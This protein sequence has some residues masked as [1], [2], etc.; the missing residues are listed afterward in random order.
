[1]TQIDE[2]PDVGVPSLASA[3]AELVVEHCS[4]HSPP[5]D[6]LVLVSDYPLDVLHATRSAILAMG[7]AQQF[8]FGDSRPALTGT[9]VTGRD[10]DVIQILPYCVDEDSEGQTQSQGYA[11]KLRDN[12]PYLLPKPARLRARWLILLGKPAALD[13]DTFVTTTQRARFTQLGQPGGRDRVLRCLRQK[14]PAIEDK[15]DIVTELYLDKGRRFVD[16]Q[17]FSRLV[18]FYQG[19]RDFDALCEALPTL[20]FVP[21]RYPRYVPTARFRMRLERN[22]DFAHQ[23]SEVLCSSED[24][25]SWF[26]ENLKPDWAEVLKTAMWQLTHPSFEELLEHWPSGVTYSDLADIP[27]GADD[28]DGDDGD[29]PPR[30]RPKTLHQLIKAVSLTTPSGD[31]PRVLIP[32]EL[33]VLRQSRLHLDI[34]LARSLE[35]EEEL[36]IFLNGRRVRIL[37]RQTDRL[38]TDV[39]L[40]GERVGELVWIRVGAYPTPRAWDSKPR[41]IQDE[42]LFLIPDDQEWVPYERNHRLSRGSF[43]AGE[44]VEIGIEPL[45]VWEGETSLSIEGV[46][47][48]GR[49]LLYQ[50]VRLDVRGFYSRSIEELRRVAQ[51]VAN[52]QV[53]ID[54][55]SVVVTDGQ[56]DAHF[57]VVLDVVREALSAQPVESIPEALL[58]WMF[59]DIHGELAGVPQE[60]EFVYRFQRDEDLEIKIGPAGSQLESPVARR[61]RIHIPWLYSK[62]E[63]DFLRSPANPFAFVLEGVDEETKSCRTRRVGDGD[64]PNWRL[65]FSGWSSYDSFI[66][67]R[68]VLFRRLTDCMGT[69]RISTLVGLELAELAP[70][71]EAYANSYGELLGAVEDRYLRENSGNPIPSCNALMFVDTVLVPSDRVAV[72]PYSMVLVAPTHPLRLLFLLRVEQLVLAWQQSGRAEDSGFRLFPPDFGQISAANLPLFLCN[73]GRSQRS[74]FAA[75]PPPNYHWGMLLPFED[76]LLN[77]F[78]TDSSLGDAAQRCLFSNYAEASTSSLASAMRSR[79]DAF[80]EAH[81]Y[82]GLPDTTVLINAFNPGTGE[83]ILA[84]IQQIVDSRQDECPSFFVRLVDLREAGEP[85]VP[86]PTIGAAFDTLF[87]R[88]EVTEKQRMMRSKLTY[89]VVALSETSLRQGA[90][91][92][93][94]YAHLHFVADFFKSRVSVSRMDKFPPSVALAG[95]MPAFDLQF[96]I[97]D[98]LF[99]AGL[100]FPARSESESP[101][102]GL[103]SLSRRLAQLVAAEANPPLAPDHALYT[104]LGFDRASKQRIL[105]LHKHGIWVCFL[106][107]DVGIEGFDFPQLSSKSESRDIFLLDY[108]R[109]Y[110]QELGGYD[111]I[112]TTQKIE[113]V[114]SIIQNHLSQS[115]YGLADHGEQVGAQ[116]ILARVSALS[117][118]WGMTLSNMLPNEIGGICGNA[119]VF[120]YLELEQQRFRLRTQDRSR[121][122]SILLPT[123]EYLRV[124]GKDGRPL[125]SGW[126]SQSPY[127][128]G[129]CSDDLLELRLTSLEGG[130][131]HL[132]GTIIE[133]KHGVAASS[134]LGEAKEQ[135]VNARRILTHR[136]VERWDDRIDKPFRQSELARLI[137]F[138]GTKLARHQVY[139]IGDNE[140]EAREFLYAV[141]SAVQ[142]GNFSL[143]FEHA[144]VPSSEQSVVPVSGVVALV[145]LSAK[146]NYL[147]RPE[148]VVERTPGGDNVGVW[149][150][151]AGYVRTLLELDSSF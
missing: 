42:H 102:F 124:S 44:T 54:R 138:H 150:L 60:Y 10:G 116:R 123:D 46:S 145:D 27:K 19:A 136:F 112:T 8:C 77:R 5:S 130:Q 89:S 70:F 2:T 105:P 83:D 96:S 134:R 64:E 90:Y 109:K 131:C 15:L 62:L 52:Q 79:I 91:P 65:D 126:R 61:F 36:R 120:L 81:P 115:R 143:S 66:A 22:W 34:S 137:S 118:R 141:A 49:W 38:T 20:G 43:T 151:P 149:H 51:K 121:C 25:D 85:P 94:Y 41:D 39:D 1:M 84:A 82:L 59:G 72:K 16:D 98:S 53:D 113:S 75:G 9:N 139:G 18:Q 24:V 6:A 142:A 57:D 35:Q 45:S 107:R 133:V 80:L 127:R 106:D 40:S 93:R 111:L 132:A 68:E 30:R 140:R 146:A 103:E 50:D 119:V 32:E 4:S 99:Y 110:E 48:T 117:G 128:D 144:F 108:T 13:L 14:A 31:P 114:R 17:S 122:L 74:V 3:L 129:K 37:T 12:F 58:A 56:H 97:A 69:A 78:L 63:A 88:L 86:D 26:D 11:G 104:A 28:E 125:R 135:V 23:L 29:P 148:A 76:R 47:R 21:D 87:T 67:A 73:L 100:W 33:G 55:V 71:I 7:E 101:E 147:T 95:L 92:Q